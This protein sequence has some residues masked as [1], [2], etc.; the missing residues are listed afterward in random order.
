MHF[1]HV[2]NILFGS[3]LSFVI[4]FYSIPVII[5]VANWKKLYDLPGDRKIHSAPVPSL[6]GLGIFVGFML[7]VLLFTNAQEVFGVFQYF[8][9]C[10]IVIFFFGIKDD[11]LMLSPM[12]KFM[13]QMAVVAILM[14]KANLL[15]T[16]MYGFLNIT[17]I[18]PAVSYLLTGFTILVVMNAY[19]LID[20]VDG[21]AGSLSVITCLS[22]GTFFL[23]SDDIFYALLGYSFAAS[24]MAFLIY[25]YSPA[26]IFMGDTGAMLAGAVNAILVIRFIETGEQSQILPILTTPAIG[27]GI[28]MI[29]LLDTLR[30]FAI[31]ILHG[32]SPFSPDRNHVHHLMLD[33]GFSHRK[34]TLSLSGLSILFIFLSYL[35]MPLGTTKVIGLQVLVFFA[36]IS[37]L[38][39][40]PRK[41]A[42][43]RVI[44]GSKLER[45][46]RFRRSVRNFLS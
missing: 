31:R 8:I 30:V 21:L 13:G 11:I 40:Y 36:G 39:Y 45:Q 9:A 18:D 38:K 25:N 5:L 41:T 10:F 32:R 4:T 16:N 27:F 3:I 34:I 17:Y 28:L 12:K 33:R 7:G 20:G 26:R 23:L 46:E 1:Q 22:F 37:L 43:M 2:E 19:N 35:A 24:L 15:I 29:P 42:Q 6:G 44:K 14:F